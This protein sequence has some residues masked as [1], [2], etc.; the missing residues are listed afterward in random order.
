M[1]EYSEAV[2]KRWRVCFIAGQCPS[3]LDLLTRSER[4]NR[5]IDNDSNE[6]NCWWRLDSHSVTILK[7]VFVHWWTLLR[8]HVLREFPEWKSL[9]LDVRIRLDVR[10]ILPELLGIWSLCVTCAFRPAC[11]VNTTHSANLISHFIFCS[12]ALWL[13][14]YLYTYDLVWFLC[15]DTQQDV[16]LPHQSHS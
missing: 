2:F 14:M 5:C 15:E 8:E 12:M 13:T 11:K 10:L 4:Y 9:C 1:L 3:P 16:M 7:S 6:H